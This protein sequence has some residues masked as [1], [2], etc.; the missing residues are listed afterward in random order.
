M[1]S[2]PWERDRSLSRSV[3]IVW[4]TEVEETRLLMAPGGPP[5]LTTMWC[6]KLHGQ[7]YRILLIVTHSVESI[8]W[9]SV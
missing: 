1:W 5:M 7:N 2:E 3:G 6:I 9:Y 8:R 4:S